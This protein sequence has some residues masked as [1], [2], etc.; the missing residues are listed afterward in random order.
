MESGSRSR[1]FLHFLSVLSLTSL[2]VVSEPSAISVLAQDVLTQ[3]NDNQRTGANLKET[4]LTPQNVKS[5]FGL[6]Y[7]RKV[8]GYIYPHR[9]CTNIQVE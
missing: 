6:L 3:H 1:R 4:I 2:F 9:P 7:S 5:G 8:E